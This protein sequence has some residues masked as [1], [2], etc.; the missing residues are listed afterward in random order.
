MK[1]KYT[2]LLFSLF[3]NFSIAQIANPASNINLCIT[4][5]SG[6]SCDFDFSNSI[7]EII[8]AQNPS[9]LVVTFHATNMDAITNTNTLPVTGFCNTSNPQTIYARLQNVTSEMFD[10][11]SFD[12]SVSQNPIIN[13]PLPLELCDDEAS[14]SINDEISTFD[15]TSNYNSIIGGSTGLSVEY[16]KNSNDL[17]NDI[18][19]ATPTAY[20]NTVMPENILIKITSTEGCETIVNQTLRVL[21]TPGS[22]ESY[23]L[24]Y[25]CDDDMDGFATVD[26]TQGFPPPFLPLSFIVYESL[27]DAE[28]ETNPISNSS[29]YTVNINDANAEGIIT[30]YIRTTEIFTGCYSVGPQDVSVN[31]NTINRINGNIVYDFDE[32][33]CNTSTYDAANLLVEATDGTTTYNT[34]TQTDGSYSIF[35]D[36]EG[37]FTTTVIA[38]ELSSLFSISPSSISSTFTGLGNEDTADFCFT[39]IG[40]TNN[41]SVSTY[42]LSSARP[43]F[44]TS[45]VIAYKNTGTTLQSGDILFEYDDSKMQFLSASET[46][47]SSTSNSLT[48]N[49]VDLIPFETRTII[50]DFNVFTPPTTNIDDVLNFITTINPITGDAIPDDNVFN[51]NQI[52]IGSYDPNDIQVL[53]GDEI[54]LE[55]TDEFLHYIIRFQNTGTASAINVHVE[56]VLDID[57]DRSTFRLENLSHSGRVEIKNGNELDFIFDGINLPDSTSDEPNSHGYI[58][59]KIKP[60]TNASLGDVFSNTA[61]IYFD[62]N[63]PITTNTV[64]TIVVDVLSVTENQF[65][66]FAIFPNPSTDILNITGTNTIKNIDIY[67]IT[68]KH[69][70]SIS[71]K[72]NVSNTQINLQDLSFG[73]YSLEVITTENQK[74][75]HKIIK[76]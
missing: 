10:T 35:I 20:Q 68:G 2:L 63:P 76:K 71:I 17:I 22:P 45:Y 7:V 25:A 55:D 60:K 5:D 61:D 1:K 44:D 75:V 47:S 65:D 42:P 11:T 31:C 64:T 48:F 23:P 66:A 67:D 14:G 37:T 24:L 72:N 30:F 16:Y 36:E 38:P 54:L 56:N 41:V 49:Y 21:P 57:L 58:T 27:A 59:Y 73:M 40:S 51:Y 33:G 12:I 13:E 50:V 15:L 32:N 69:I 46:A 39:P 8:G 18:P 4:D 70:K 19:I 9:E 6:I 52:V 43:G 28:A 29:S 74:Q 3:I 53:E 26:L 62:F 34:F